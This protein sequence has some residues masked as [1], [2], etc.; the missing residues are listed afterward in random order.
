MVRRDCCQEPERWSKLWLYKDIRSALMKNMEMEAIQGLVLQLGELH[1]SEKAHWNLEAFPKMPNL[2]LLI[3]HGVQFLH[4]PKHL[5]NNLRFLDWSEYPSKSLPSNFQPIELFELHLLHSK[6]ERLWKETKYLDKLKLIKLN[7]SLNLIATPDFTGVPNLE[8]LVL[9]GCIKL[10]EVHP[11]IMVLKRLTLLDLENCKSLRRLP[12]KFEMESLEILILSG[13][14]KIKRIPE[15]M[16][17]MK[18]LSKLHLNATAITKLPSSIEHL[19]NL[20]SLHLRDCKNLVCFPSIFC[21]FKSL[22]DINLAGCLKLDGL[23]KKLW[24]VESLEKLNVSGITL[25]EPPSSVTLENLKELSLQG[26]KEPPHKLW[27]NLFPLNL[28]PRRSLNPVSLLLPS[29]LGMHSLK[30]LDLRDC[31]LQIIPNDIGNLSSITELYLSENHF[32]CLPESMVQL[33]K[34]ELI[35]LNNCTRLRSLSQLPSTISMVEAEGCT[36]LETCPNGFKSHNSY[37][38]LSLINCFKLVRQN[39]MIS[40]ALRMLLTAAHEEICKEFIGPYILGGFIFKI[41]IPGCEIPKWF[42]HQS[43]GNTVSAQVTHPNK[44]KWIGIAM[45]VVPMAYP[46]YWEYLE[47]EI[48][49]N[50]RHVSG[51]YLSYSPRSVKIKS[52]HLWMTYIPYHVISVNMRAVLDQIDENG[53]IQMELRFRLTIGGPGFHQV[54]FRLVY[55]QDLEDIREMLSAQSSNNTCITPYEGLDVHHNSTEEIKLKR[56]RDEYEGAGAS[57]EGSSNDDSN[58]VSHS[59]LSHSSSAAPEVVASSGKTVC[60]DTC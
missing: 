18:S 13:C 40:Y 29:L 46:G 44:N 9:N 16:E 39:D 5:S 50:E 19:T 7:N 17:N 24:N 51:F 1:N 58:E 15:F 36:S 12:S 59:S 21:S 14:S 45:C 34:L 54:G 41:V 8:K 53:F 52:D 27:N 32:S 60:E 20:T 11:S 56:S 10:P 23:P 33:S 6:I 4:G 3:I 35:D 30:R 55:E 38:S 49:V 47:C 57:G 2:K 31:N 25:R 37:T 22:K 43:V 42:T 26:C 28:M 48:L